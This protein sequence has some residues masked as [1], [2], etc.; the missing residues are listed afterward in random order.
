[1]VDYNKVKKHL[2]DELNDILEYLE[3]SSQASDKLERQV[4]KDAAKDEY[5]HAK[6]LKVIL[7]KNSDIRLTDSE[8]QLWDKAEDA[9]MHA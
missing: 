3:M 7:D 1:M 2:I 4:F 9:A 5:S 8:K 6:F